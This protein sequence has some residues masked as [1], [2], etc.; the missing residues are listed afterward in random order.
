MDKYL[1]CFAV[2]PFCSIFIILGGWLMVYVGRKIVLGIQARHWPQATGRVVSLE[3]KDASDADTRSR[4]ILVRYVYSV[5]GREYEGRTIHPAYEG[6]SFE[7]AH[8]GLESLLRPPQQVRVYHDGSQPGRSML[9]VGFYSGSLGL[10]FFGFTFLC[11][12]MG[13]LLIA[14]GAR[15]LSGDF[16]LGVFLGF[17]L[18]FGFLMAGDWNFA[19]GI[20]VLS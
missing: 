17:L 5:E 2:V 15:S 20:T 8:R 7:Q 11:G 19:R 6:S 9:S 1:L 12:G 3:S 13:F 16:F 14:V 10:F 18:L 4:E